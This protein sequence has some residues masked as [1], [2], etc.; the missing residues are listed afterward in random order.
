M[1][2][3]RENPLGDPRLADRI[4]KPRINQIANASDVRADCKVLREIG[5]KPGSIIDQEISRLVS[6]SRVHGRGFARFHRSL[7]GQWKTSH[8]RGNVNSSSPRARIVLVPFV[9]RDSGEKVSAKDSGRGFNGQFSHSKHSKIVNHRRFEVSC[10]D[11]QSDPSNFFSIPC[12]RVWVVHFFF[13]RNLYASGPFIYGRS[14]V[15][16]LEIN[17]LING[18]R[19]STSYFSKS[20]IDEKNDCPFSYDRIEQNCGLYRNIF[21]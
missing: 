21:S 18:N 3:T 20:K 14:E 2:E 9:T 12:F 7:P 15:L 19:R 16:F 6:G 13:T 8:S 5:R 10:G 11:L 4:G 1:A 17:W